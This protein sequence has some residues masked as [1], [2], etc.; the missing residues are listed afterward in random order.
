MQVLYNTGIE[1]K[2]KP[3]I[4]INQITP[5][6]YFDLRPNYQKVRFEN[7][8]TNAVFIAAPRP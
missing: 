1:L 5:N 8:S 2:F 4:P 6:E 3:I 7:D